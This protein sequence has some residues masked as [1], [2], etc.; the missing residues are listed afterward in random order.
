LSKVTPAEHSAARARNPD[1]RR[2]AF[3]YAVIAFNQELK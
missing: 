3:K 2:P 1:A